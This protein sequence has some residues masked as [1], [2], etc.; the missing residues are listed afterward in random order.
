MQLKYYPIVPFNPV[1]SAAQASFIAINDKREKGVSLPEHPYAKHFFKTYFGTSTPNS[2]QM[3]MLGCHIGR[4]MFSKKQYVEA[5]DALIASDGRAY[6]FPLTQLD[7]KLIYPWVHH[8]QKNRAVQRQDM[9]MEAETRATEK[10]LHLDTTTKEQTESQYVG[11]AVDK[12]NQCRT[13]DD[14][15]QW[16]ER[17]CASWEPANSRR[18]LKNAI[19]KIGYELLPKERH[20][21]LAH[22]E[23]Y[24]SGDTNKTVY[25]FMGLTDLLKELSATNAT[26]L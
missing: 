11:A 4:E 13:V 19:L 22:P 2:N 12:L 14:L 23:W 24:Y 16:W 9:R 26:I 5:Y 18:D 7:V 20:A 6:P 15:T 17:Y 21:D 3:R 25:Y 1:L 8:A 10:V